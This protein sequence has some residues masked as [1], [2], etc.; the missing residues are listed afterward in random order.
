M[1]N[2]VYIIWIPYNRVF[3]CCQIFAVLSKKT[4][5]IFYADFN[6]CGRQH[7][8]KISFFHEN[9]ILGGTTWLSLDRPIVWKENLWPEYLKRKGIKHTCSL[10]DKQTKSRRLNKMTVQ[11]KTMKCPSCSLVTLCHMTLF[12]IKQLVVYSECKA[13]VFVDNL[14]YGFLSQKMG[15]RSKKK[16]KTIN[17]FFF[18]FNLQNYWVG[19]N[20]K[21]KDQVTEKKLQVFWLITNI[22]FKK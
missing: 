17:F 21:K 9:R 2:I 15:R 16:K 6:Y 10:T 20:K 1:A 13:F 4:W 18:F 12:A 7:P 3:S 19:Q 5:G 14:V 11:N 8:R 22:L